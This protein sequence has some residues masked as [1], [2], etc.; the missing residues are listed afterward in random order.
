MNM[1]NRFFRSNI[2][3]G[4]KTFYDNNVIIDN[5]Y[6]DYSSQGDTHEYFSWHPI[7]SLSKE[8]INFNCSK[9]KFINS[10]HNDSNKPLSHFIQ[11]IDCILGATYTCLHNP[12]KIEKKKVVA[13]NY[14]NVLSTIMGKMPGKA[15]KNSTYYRCNH[16]SFFPKNK[17][18]YAATIDGKD[19]AF[20]D[21][22]NYYYDRDIPLNNIPTTESLDVYL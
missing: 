15:Y 5:I 11:L 2:K 14:Y 17:L 18:S 6:H 21:K 20:K 9:I 8:G 10:N 1:Y 3:Y 4:I 7:Y 19:T 16:I 13:K 12:T 22:N